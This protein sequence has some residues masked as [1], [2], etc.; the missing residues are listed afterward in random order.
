ME[1]TTQTIDAYRSVGREIGREQGCTA[2]GVLFAGTC[3]EYLH[4]WQSGATT[5]DTPAETLL[6]ALC[7]DPLATRAGDELGVVAVTRITNWVSVNWHIVG[8]RVRLLVDAEG[9]DTAEEVAY[10]TVA[11]Q[12]ALAVANDHRVA[13]AV[14][15]GAAAVARLRRHSRSD[16]EGSAEDQLA[17][18][19]E[20]DPAVAAAW[21]ELNEKG[22]RGVSSWV[23]SRW[24]EIVSSAEELVA[25]DWL[26]SPV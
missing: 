7:G 23:I 10:R 24:S 17:E 8:E 21:D 15:A 9:A 14:L 12:M 6:E 2:A 1:T 25:L 19:A 26:A 11:S 22:R 16:I 4:R 3:A 20:T 18:M 13:R 5:A